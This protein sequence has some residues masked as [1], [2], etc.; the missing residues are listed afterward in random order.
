MECGA[1][2]RLKLLTLRVDDRPLLRLNGVWCSSEIETNTD[3]SNRSF[4]DPSKWSV[5]LVG[6]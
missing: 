4:V 1:R 3:T 5:V 6:D 2:R